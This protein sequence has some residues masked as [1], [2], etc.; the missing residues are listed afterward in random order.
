MIELIAII[1]SS[2]LEEKPERT[3]EK[4]WKALRKE[5]RRFENMGG[6]LIMAVPLWENIEDN[7]FDY[8]R[9]DVIDVAL[10]FAN[11]TA[12]WLSDQALLSD[13]DREI[14]LQ[15]ADEFGMM[16]V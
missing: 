14:M 8:E 16:R 15:V 3:K 2:L 9:I 11:N 7:Q 4:F 12:M 6:G 13:E 1:I 5:I 10:F